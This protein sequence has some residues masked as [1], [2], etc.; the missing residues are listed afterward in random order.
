[1]LIAAV[2]RPLILLTLRET[3]GNQIR[4]RAARAKPQHV[5]KENSRSGYPGQASQGELGS[6]RQHL[7]RNSDPSVRS[8][9]PQVANH[10]RSTMTKEELI[11]KMA[12]SAGITKSPRPSH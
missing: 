11:A 10:S 4:R 9:R 7:T 5:E 12:S 1:M 3:K 6:Y 2:E 8:S